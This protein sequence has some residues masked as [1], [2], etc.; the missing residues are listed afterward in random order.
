MILQGTINSDQVVQIHILIR[1][2]QAAVASGSFWTQVL[3][4]ARGYYVYTAPLAQTGTVEWDP[5]GPGEEC[6]VEQ[7][8]NRTRKMPVIRTALGVDVSGRGGVQ[9]PLRQASAY[10]WRS[11][12]EG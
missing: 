2:P 3:S 8:E 12:P 11:V 5:R 1:V 7:P 6:G 10:S 4:L 9:R